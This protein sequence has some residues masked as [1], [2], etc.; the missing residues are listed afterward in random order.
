MTAPFLAIAVMILLAYGRPCPAA[1]KS[2][3]R[4][5]KSCASVAVQAGAKGSAGVV[6]PVVAVNSASQDELQ[7]LPGIGPAKAA[8]LMDA[9][10]KRPFKRPSDLRRV[11]GFGAKTIQRLAP[12]MSF[13]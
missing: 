1:G 9:R 4:S 10:S 11:K 3:G 13:D 7:C 8:A 2:D 12:L 5:G 6:Q